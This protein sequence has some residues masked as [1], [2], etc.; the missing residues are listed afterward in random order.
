MNCGTCHQEANQESSGVPG[1][2]HWHLAPIGMAWEGLSDAELC[3]T[4]LDRGKNGGRTVDDLVHHMEED[5]L[6]RW[7][8]EPGGQRTTPPLAREEFL[9]VVRAWAAKGAAC[10]NARG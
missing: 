7:A 2:P 8:W 10:P 3:R 4:V 5:A 1:A 9:D 6:V